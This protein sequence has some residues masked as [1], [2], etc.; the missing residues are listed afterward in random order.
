MIS[1]CDECKNTI[2]T[3]SCTTNYCFK[4]LWIFND[5]SEEHVKQLQ[6]IGQKRTISKGDMVFRQGDSAHDIFLIKYGRIK[7]SKVNIDGTEITLD[8]RK[9]GDTLGE[10]VFSDE[11]L[12]P[13]S[14]IAIEETT[15]CGITF[16]DFQKLIL[17]NPEMGLKVISSMSRKITAM[18]HR[19]ENSTEKSLEEKLFSTLST[20]AYEHT[21]AKAVN[22]CIP[23]P[24]THEE[25]AFLVGAH[26]VS[27]TKALNALIAKEKNLYYQQVDYFS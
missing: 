10:N 14:A 8:F 11:E 5:F 2:P 9:A 23:F 24:L 22:P 19:L 13:V 21:D 20:I 1:I 16:P 3:G 6:T 4:D 17:K 18:T 15:T 27:I 12:Y 26:R 25:L 7:L